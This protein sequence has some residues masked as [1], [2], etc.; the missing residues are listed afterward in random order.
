M[1]NFKELLDEAKKDNSIKKQ[2]D[3][4][5]R[6]QGMRLLELGGYEQEEFS[7]MKDER[8]IKVAV[9]FDKV[10]GSRVRANKIIEFF[11]KI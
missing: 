3:A 5:D 7:Y 11:K 9:K 2:I 6:I 4:E 10:A 1:N 8:I